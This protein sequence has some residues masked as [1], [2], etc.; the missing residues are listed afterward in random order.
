[1]FL[2]TPNS[3]YSMLLGTGYSSNSTQAGNQKL[4]SSIPVYCIECNVR[5][6]FH[7]HLWAGSKENHLLLK[8]LHVFSRKN[9]IHFY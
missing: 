5:P 2:P 4:L 6:I 8:V 7:L 9:N 1:M 3:L